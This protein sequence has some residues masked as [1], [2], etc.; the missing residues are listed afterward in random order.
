MPSYLWLVAAVAVCLA[1]WLTARGPGPRQPPPASATL[2]VA[3]PPSMLAPTPTPTPIP[4]TSSPLLV[5]SR[6]RMAEGEPLLSG[7]A[8]LSGQPRPPRGDLE[9]TLWNSRSG[10]L[11]WQGSVARSDTRE[12]SVV[13]DGTTLYSGSAGFMRPLEPGAWEEGDSLVLEARWDEWTTRQ[14]VPGPPPT[15]PPR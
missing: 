8:V 14:E 7:T 12:S 4:E 11:V 5:V 9:L 6:L 3:A 10:A 13:L 1:V 15:T 2:V